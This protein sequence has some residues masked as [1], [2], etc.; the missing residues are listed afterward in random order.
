MSNHTEW[1]APAQAEG[2]AA[3]LF[4][5][6]TPAGAPPEEPRRRSRAS[7]R[8]RQEKVK[9]QRRRRSYA[10]LAVALVMVAGAGYVVFSLFGGALGGLFG[11]GS[12][13]AAAV[14]DYT[15]PGRPGGEPV[16][17]PA[18]ATGADMATALVDAGVVASEGA[19]LDAFEANPDAASIQPG[20]YKLLLEMKA[21]EAVV[22][23]LDPKSRATMNV[24][25]PE[26]YT[27]EQIYQRINEVTL[28]SVEDLKAAAADPAAIGLPAEAGGNPEGWLFPSTYPVE[29]D[30]SAASV[31]KQMTTKTVELLT[32]KG[33]AQDQWQTVLIKAS[34][35]EREARHDEDRPKMARAIQNRI[36]QDMRLQIDASL[37]YGLG[38]SGTELTTDMLDTSD[39]PYNLN[40]RVGL[41]PTPIASPG[42]KSIDAVLNPAD[43]SWL[44]WM[45]VNLDTGET[46]FATTNDEHEENRALYRQWVAENS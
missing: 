25:I 15:G 42:E 8:R 11:G 32:A 23:L 24:T 27:A 22:A 26:G 19:F 45:T 2:G 18:G 14:T 20:T 40:L 44:F 4:G 31:L 6:R 21:S 16:V 30:A 41:P 10:I 13:S 5:D 9:K 7:S 17:I 39:S 3:D 34:L 46:R 12:S 36:D 28:I 29:P 1:W 37:A 35:I 33:I 38:I 43:G